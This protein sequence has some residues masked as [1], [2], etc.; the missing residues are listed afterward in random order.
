M[1]RNCFPT[2]IHHYHSKHRNF[3]EAFPQRSEDVKTKGLKSSDVAK[4]KVLVTSVTQK[5]KAKECLLTVLW[6]L[7]KYK[8]IFF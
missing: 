2:L 3:E 5:Q 4:S 1:P 7:G 8:K 6:A